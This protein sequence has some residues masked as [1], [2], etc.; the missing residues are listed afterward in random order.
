MCSDFGSLDPAN[1]LENN[2]LAFR[3]AEEQLGI[4][5]LLD[6]EDMVSSSVPDRLSVLTYVS[7]YYQAFASMGLNIGGCSPKNSPKADCRMKIPDAVCDDDTTTISINK[8]NLNSSKNNEDMMGMPAYEQTITN[9]KIEDTPC[10]RVGIKD[11]VVGVMYGGS[12]QSTKAS[13][14]IPIKPSPTQSPAPYKAPVK[15][16]SFSSVPATTTVLS[17]TTTASPSSP[18]PVSTPSK[19]TSPYSSSYTSPYSSRYR[20]GSFSN[21]SSS[22]SDMSDSIDT[23]AFRASAGRVLTTSSSTTSS[24]V[25]LRQHPSTTTV[26]TTTSTGGDTVNTAQSP[27]YETEAAQTIK[28]ATIQERIRSLTLATSPINKVRVHSLVCLV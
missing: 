4:P 10:K 5:A 1:V 20:T 12:R 9:S 22:G 7:Q 8:S 18:A 28:I 19:Y 24:P 21:R 25:E 6:A 26:T 11:R 14:P 23:S 3:V 17:S 16:S 2:E 15:T 27:A 13:S